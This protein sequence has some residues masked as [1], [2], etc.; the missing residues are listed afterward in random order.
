MGVG[1]HST[2]SSYFQAFLNRLDDDER[3]ADC[4]YTT[5][6]I[7]LLYDIVDRLPPELLDTICDD[8][9]ENGLQKLRVSK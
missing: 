3:L 7:E 1:G 8:I 4:L 5:L 9:L 2:N 6:L